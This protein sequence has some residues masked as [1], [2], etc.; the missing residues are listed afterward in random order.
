MN[1]LET[2]FDKLVKKYTNEGKVNIIADKDYDTIMDTIRKDLEE[3]RLKEQE[4]RM[5]SAETIASVVLTA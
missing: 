1:N 4:R 2:H 3:F 5:R